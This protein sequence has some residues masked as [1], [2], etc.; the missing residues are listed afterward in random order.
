V[1][2]KAQTKKETAKEEEGFK[3]YSKM[4][5]GFYQ[6][7]PLPAAVEPDNVKATYK[8]GVLE[9]VLPKTEVQ[10]SQITIE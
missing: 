6:C 8:N 7:I 10:K 3:A 1:E 2:I 9:V 4:Y 5:A